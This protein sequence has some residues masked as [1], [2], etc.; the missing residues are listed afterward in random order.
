MRRSQLGVLLLVVAGCDPGGPTKPEAI[1]VTFHLANPLGIERPEALRLAVV[2]KTGQGTGSPWLTTY[3]VAVA[4]AQQGQS[5]RVELPEGVTLGALPEPVA[6]RFRCAAWTEA[7][8]WPGVRP[9][10]VVY[11]DLDRNQRLEGVGVDRIW[12]MTDFSSSHL[13]AFADFDRALAE[14]SIED[15]ECLRAV[16]GGGFSPFV[17]GSG[18][19]SFNVSATPSSD[20][21][22]IVNP[23]DFPQVLLTCPAPYSVAQTPAPEPRRLAVAPGIELDGCTDDATCTHVTY[24][25]D[26]A[27]A[28]QPIHAPGFFRFARCVVA[29]AA[30][31]LWIRERRSECNDCACILHSQDR[32]WAVSRA[33]RPSDWPCGDSVEICSATSLQIDLI[34]DDCL[35]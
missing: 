17:S 11:E 26:W 4:D 5:V 22:L 14:V 32:G 1:N 28:I 6:I 15:A 35:P 34:P 18:A 19:Q 21:T 7:R 20:F 3:D 8:T 12:A 23:S 13:V 2:W 29:G 24:D 9:L 10:W 31:V 27:A 33:D 25:S 16:T 30:E